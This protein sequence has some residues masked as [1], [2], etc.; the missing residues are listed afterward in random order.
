MTS[1]LHAALVELRDDPLYRFAD[2][3]NPAVPNGRMPRSE[4]RKR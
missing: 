1:D 4:G 3:P 2:W